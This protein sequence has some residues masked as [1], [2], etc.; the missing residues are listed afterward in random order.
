MMVV[1]GGYRLGVV[2]SVVCVPV[3][4]RARGSFLTLAVFDKSRF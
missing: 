4:D 2:V 1:D 3:R